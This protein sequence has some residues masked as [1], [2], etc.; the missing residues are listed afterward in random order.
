MKHTLN[1]QKT[2]LKVRVNSSLLTERFTLM[3]TFANYVPFSSSAW[4]PVVI[5]DHRYN[6]YTVSY[7][8]YIESLLPSPKTNDGFTPFLFDRCVNNCVN[9]KL[10]SSNLT[11]SERFSHPSKAR[12]VS[13]FDRKQDLF[14]ILLA[15]IQ[16]ECT[17]GCLEY[18]D[19]IMVENKKDIELYVPIVKPK[20]KSGETRRDLTAISL[21]ST[22]HPVLSIIFKLKIS[23]FQQIINLG[24]ILGLWFGFSAVS[25]ARVGRTRDKHIGLDELLSLGR[26]TRALKAQYSIS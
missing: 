15:K 24:S 12:F 5:K 26:R 14:R 8:R 7:I 2:L 6:H 22:N 23:F 18:N 13:Y 21:K 25:L 3:V 10:R 17:A 9:K 11:L 19:Y 4:A 20:R 1:Q 16:Q